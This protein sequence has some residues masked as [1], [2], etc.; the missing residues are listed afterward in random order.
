MR[1]PSV[2]FDGEKVLFQQGDQWLIAIDRSQ[3]PNP[4]TAP[5]KLASM[6]V[7]VDPRA[8][9]KQMYHEVWRI[10]RDFLYDPAITG[11]TL[12]RR[13]SFTRRTSTSVCQPRTI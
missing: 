8:E 5:L 1:T 4:A 2:S 13:R 10:E 12:P 7:Y 6:E 3:P 9:W 11:S